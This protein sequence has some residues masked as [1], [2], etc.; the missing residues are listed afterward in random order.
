VRQETGDYP[1]ATSLLDQAL[2]TYRDIGSPPGEAD[3]LNQMGTLHLARL[4][5][6]HPD[7]AT[8]TPPGA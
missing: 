7:P 1:A 2:R 4:A 5:P 8:V 6:G 3:V